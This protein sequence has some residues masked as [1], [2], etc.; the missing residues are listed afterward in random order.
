MFL[1]IIYAPLL[2]IAR[3]KI[4]LLSIA[5]ACVQPTDSL[6]IMFWNVE[7][8]FDWRDGATSPSDSEFSS[9]GARHWTSKRFHVKCNIIVKTIFWIADRYGGLPDVICFAEVEN[10]FVLK[11]L[12]SGTA[13]KKT[14]YSIVHYD[15]PDPRGIDVA[16]LFRKT[17]LDTVMTGAVGISDFATRD[18]LLAQFKTQAGDSLAV[19]VN[20][21]PSKYGGASSEDRRRAVVHVLHGLTDSLSRAGWAFQVAVGDFNDT[22]DSEIYDALDTSFVNISAKAADDGSI[23]F[24]GKWELID[25]C[26]VTPALATRSRTEVCRIP[27]LMTRDSAYGGEKPLRTYVGPRYTGGVS[28][29]CPI[30]SMI[31]F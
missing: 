30:F 22:P 10:D 7:N 16:L 19:T 3:M 9:G 23:R 18:I 25:Q 28:D 8:F 2:Q 5:L 6:G 24:A 14:D 1:I 15:S 17:R 26:F 11:R 21:H 20:H 4:L 31:V 12:I 29:H 13:L 27:F